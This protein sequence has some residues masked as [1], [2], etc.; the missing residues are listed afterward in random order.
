MQN[1]EGLAQA[2]SDE[3]E[4]GHY[5]REEARQA[6]SNALDMVSL[7]AD[8]GGRDWAIVARAPLELDARRFRVAVEAIGAHVQLLACARWRIEITYV[9]TEDDLLAY[10]AVRSSRLFPRPE[11]ET[12]EFLIDLGVWPED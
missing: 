9:E 10:L 11:E 3:P 2:E 8:H 5:L 6:L 1:N 7:S 4:N 12:I